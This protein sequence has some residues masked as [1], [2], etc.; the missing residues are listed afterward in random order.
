VSP[1]GVQGRGG[2]NTLMVQS[3][4]QSGDRMHQVHSVHRRRERCAAIVGALAVL[5]MAACG[6][7]GDTQPA[8]SP[9]PPPSDAENVPASV[10]MGG[11]KSVTTFFVTSKGPGNGGALGG[12]AGADAHCQALAKAEGSGDHTWRAYLST[13]V[14]GG[15]AAVNARDRIGRGPWYNAEGTLVA[16]N[17]TQL[18]GDHNAIDKET[19]ATERL[20]PVNGVGDTPNTHDI[21]TGSRPDGTAFPA[22]EDLTC[23][24]WTSSGAGHAQVGHHDRKGQGEGAASWNSAHPTRGCSQQD[25]QS[26]GGAGLFYCFAID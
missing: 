19:A 3:M 20:D 4:V 2:I 15:E 5:V 11:A 6:P 25:L 24:N 9:A 7:A 8:A 1:F 17:L 13:T 10:A 26:T 23:G 12:L 21:L 22:G 16:A 14:V 18:H